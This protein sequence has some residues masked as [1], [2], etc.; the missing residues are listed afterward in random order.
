[1][2]EGRVVEIYIGPKPEGPVRRVEEVVAVAGRGLE[3]D[4]YFQPG[5]DGVP[6]K[7]ITLIESEAIAAAAVESSVDIQPA[8]TRRN[9]VTT[10][11]RLDELVGKTFALGEVEVEAIEPNPP[12][13]HLQKLAGK[14]L[15]KPLARRGGVRGRIVK[16]GV[17][18]AGDPITAAS[19]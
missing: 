4:R 9:V 5:A 8:D 18:R 14:P 16:G 11:V 10:G 7:E 13:N 2:S 15:L 1:M 12:C 17:L 19:P 3:G 6:D